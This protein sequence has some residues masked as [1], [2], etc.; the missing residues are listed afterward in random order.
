M[1]PERSWA[2]S[3]DWVEPSVSKRSWFRGYRFLICTGS[4]GVHLPLVKK[5]WL[6]YGQG[7]CLDAK[8]RNFLSLNAV[9]ALLEITCLGTMQ[10]N[11]LFFARKKESREQF[12][13]NE[14]EVNI[15]NT[16]DNN[17]IYWQPL[18]KGDSWLITY[19]LQAAKS[20]TA[21][22]MI[23]LQAKTRVYQSFI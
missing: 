6:F 16:W 8:D 22:A 23:M 9:L 18:T 7:P 12:D 3:P 2:Y 14:E 1:T 5:M 4:R 21:F 10:C 13:L 11:P 17:Y 15:R 19:Q 20:I